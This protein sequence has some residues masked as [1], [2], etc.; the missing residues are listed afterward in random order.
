MLGRLRRRA[1]LS[2]VIRFSIGGGSERTPPVGSSRDL[3]N[4]RIEDVRV[5]VTKIGLVPLLRDSYPGASA[6]PEIGRL[7]SRT[8]N[9]RP[10]AA[11]RLPRAAS[12]LRDARKVRVREMEQGRPRN[13]GVCGSSSRTRTW[14]PAVNSR[15]LYR[16]S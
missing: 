14:D 7:C 13:A 2:R 9:R 8:R 4:G 12:P 10:G 1:E 5:D 6:L 16:L 15:L 11:R 3:A